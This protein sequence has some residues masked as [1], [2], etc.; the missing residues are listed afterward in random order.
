MSGA[1]NTK[2]KE[3]ERKESRSVMLLSTEGLADSRRCANVLGAIA[4][5]VGLQRIT[6]QTGNTMC[7]AIGKL[8]KLKEMEI[9]HGIAEMDGGPRRLAL[10]D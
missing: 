2:A 3:I 6:P 5:D 9:K 1:S 10:T 7:N 8:L 4:L